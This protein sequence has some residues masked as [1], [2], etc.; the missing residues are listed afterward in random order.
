ME[1]FKSNIPLRIGG[2]AF[3][4]MIIAGMISY[5]FYQTLFKSMMLQAIYGFAIMGLALFLGIWAGIT[6]RRENNGYI[7]LQHAFL[8]VFITFLFCNAGN[9]ISSILV[10][11]VIDP[12]YSQKIKKM[13]KDNL[14]ETLEKYNVP[15]DK[16]QESIKKIDQEDYDP[17]SLNMMKK[18][19]YFIIGEAVLALIIA[20]FIK[21]GSKDIKE[22]SDINDLQKAEQF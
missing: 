1:K 14:V 19:F 13:V 9:L 10:N 15:D 3:V 2:I 7:T 17:T 8:A 6:Y 18:V 22:M 11:K 4:A 16:V 5:A 12:L 20:A 21:R